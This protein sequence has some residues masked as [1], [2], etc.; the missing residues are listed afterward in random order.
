MT[1]NHLLLSALLVCSVFLFSCKDDE[2]AASARENCLATRINIEA[3][4]LIACDYENGRVS[5]VR[6]YAEIHTSVIYEENRIKHLIIDPDETGEGDTTTFEYDQSGMLLHRQ[7]IYDGKAEDQVKFEWNADST[8]KSIKRYWIKNGA[9]TGP[10][11]AI[12]FTYESGDLSEILYIED[13]NRDNQLD[14]INDSYSTYR[15]TKGGVLNPFY[16]FYLYSHNSN[17]IAY[18]GNLIVPPLWFNKYMPISCT[19]SD[20]GG[21]PETFSYSSKLNAE[22]NIDQTIMDYN[23]GLEP[24]VIS[25]SYKCD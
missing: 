21:T 15:Y 8:L 10:F 9:L 20:D 7:S 24:E 12:N 23:D 6:N 17:G 1:K 2:S 13:D 14:T 4:Y 16:G 25:F 18:L 22:G 5:S 11:W 3:A 19:F